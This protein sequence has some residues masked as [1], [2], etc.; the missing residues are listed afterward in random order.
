MGKRNVEALRS[1]LAEREPG[2]EWLCKTAEIIAANALS[3]FENCD[4]L[5]E[6]LDDAE[7]KAAFSGILLAG[8]FFVVAASGLGGYGLPPMSVKN[9]GKNF[10]CVGDFSTVADQESPPLAPRVMQA[11]ALQADAVL[12]RIL[13]E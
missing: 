13:K 3:W 7:Q 6:A 9:I 8:G 10:V 5:V 1:R 2:V 12:A 4:I 11:A